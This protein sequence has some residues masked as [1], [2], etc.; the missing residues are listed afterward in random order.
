M[1]LRSDVPKRQHPAPRHLA[2]LQRYNSCSIECWFC[3][4]MAFVSKILVGVSAQHPTIA[5]LLPHCE[6]LMLASRR[7]ISRCRV[8][9]PAAPSVRCRCVATTRLPPFG[10]GKRIFPPPL[11]VIYCHVGINDHEGWVVGLYGG[12]QPKAV[13]HFFVTLTSPCH[14]ATT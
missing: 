8:V 4:N 14:R 7:A 9:F 10:K 13:E 3:Y 1:R 2:C 5:S 12:T 6:R 11:K